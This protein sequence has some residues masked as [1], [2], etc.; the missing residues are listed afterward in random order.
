[1]ARKKYFFHLREA[2]TLRTAIC[3]AYSVKFWMAVA[4][5]IGQ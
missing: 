5:P 3:I 1:M 2:C 4:E